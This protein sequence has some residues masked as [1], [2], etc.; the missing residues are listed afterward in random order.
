MEF[1]AAGADFL[2]AGKQLRPETARLRGWS[3]IEVI[4]P[5]VLT[6][7]NPVGV[8]SAEATM[9]WLSGITTSRIQPRTSASV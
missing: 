5:S 3:H 4:Q 9:T 2:G 7:A 8:P 6:D 1:Q